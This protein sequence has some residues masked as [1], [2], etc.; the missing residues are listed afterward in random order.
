MDAAV[1]S[2]RRNRCASGKRRTE[3]CLAGLWKMA[4]AVSSYY[5]NRCAPVKRCKDICLAG[6]AKIGR[7]IGQKEGRPMGQVLK[8]YLG[9]FFLLLIGLVGI[10][11]VV[12]G[13]EA[14]AARDYHAD[15]ISEIEC[16]NFNAG[17]IA[18]CKSQARKNGYELAVA[19]YVYDAER[20]QQMAEVI[21]SYDYAIPVLNLVSGHEIRGFA[22]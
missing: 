10:G 3:I 17:V 5:R 18:A 19:N 7:R 6:M 20:N 21:L 22:R 11:V 1:S 13:M 4:A 8:T 12:A 2:Y 15:V 14:A 9:L 16:S